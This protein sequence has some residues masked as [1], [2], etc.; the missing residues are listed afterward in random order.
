MS[1]AAKA[2]PS[3]AMVLAAGLG[4]RMRPITTT[5]P[6]PLIE[7]GGK[8]LIDHMLDRLAEAG[9]GDAVVN[10]HYLAALVE[11]HIRRRP[12]KSPRIVIS[13][14]RARLLETGG[15][16]KKALGQLGDEPFLVVNTDNVWADGPRP[17][18]RRLVE[19]WDETRMDVL[20]LLAPTTTSFGYEGAG[21][22]VMDAH[23]RLRR[24]RDREVCPFVFAGASVIKPSLFADTPDGAF[25]LNLVFDKAAAAGR[26]F[27]LRLEGFWMHVGTPGAIAGAEARLADSAV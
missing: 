13:D 11:S 16:V 12:A 1:D 5:T 10:V 26:L 4:K 24:R 15:G 6:K 8:P 23:G 25:S 17:N 7:I 3:R 9:I 2:K 27:G 19:Y 21:D 20:L 22:F 18:L 14:E